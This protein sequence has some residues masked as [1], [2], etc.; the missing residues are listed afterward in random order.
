MSILETLTPAYSDTNLDSEKLKAFFN[1]YVEF[2]PALARV[3]AG[4]IRQSI[5]T[6][7]FGLPFTPDNLDKIRQAV[8]A[9]YLPDL[10]PLSSQK[11]DVSN[12]AGNVGVSTAQ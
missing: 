7:D 6:G 4:N 9:G 10:T 11:P 5:K 12:S 8:L 3:M 1:W 2:N